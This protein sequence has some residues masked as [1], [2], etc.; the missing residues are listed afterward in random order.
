MKILFVITYLMMAGKVFGQGLFNTGSDIFIPSDQGVVPMLQTVTGETFT[1]INILAGRGA[2]WTFQTNPPTSDIAVKEIAHP[3]SLHKV[4]QLS[5][6]GLEGGQSYTL[7]I[8]NRNGD[9]IDERGFKTFARNQ[10][11]LRI[12]LGSCMADCPTFQG[13]SPRIWK[14]VEKSLPELILLGGDNVYVDDWHSLGKR[15][16]PQRHEIW[17][18]YVD[19]FKEISLFKFKNL[20]PALSIWDD[21]DYGKNDS[22]RTWSSLQDGWNPVEEAKKS[23]DAF[24]GGGENLSARVFENGPGISSRVDVAGHRFVL[25]DNRTFRSPTDEAFGHLGEAQENFL[26]QQIKDSPYPLFIVTGGPFFGGYLSKE[27]FEYAHA[28]NFASFKQRIREM[29]EHAPFVLV[30]GDVHFSELMS[31]EEKELGFKTYEL[32]ASSWHSRAWGG[33][34]FDR[35]RFLSW[36]N[37]RRVWAVVGHNFL[38]ADSSFEK[39]TLKMDLSAYGPEGRVEGTGTLLNVKNDPCADLLR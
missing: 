25:L 38:L 9:A 2:D 36:K 10:H 14:Q 20:I 33:E 3:P 17:H 35:E 19:S 31:I 11:Q 13:K 24:F 39:G 4:Y 18:R 15:V 21:H 37:P 5:I 30:S 34:K 27:S 8:F 29:G 12:A 7:S 32:T 16:P 26:I 6:E 28:Q 22:D 1:R 23:F